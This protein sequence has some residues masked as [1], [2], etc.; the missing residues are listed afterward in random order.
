MEKYTLIARRIGLS[1]TVSP[2]VT[3]SN[4]ILLPI[5]TK[6]LAIADYGTWALIM[7]TINLLPALVA[8]GLPNSLVR[9]G[10]AAKDKHDIREIFYSMGFIVL[11]VSLI[12]SGL[13]FLFAPQIAASLFQNNLTIALLLI[14]NILVACLIYFVMQ[15]FVTFQQIKIYSVLS[16]F[17]AYLST[18]LIA[19]FVLS[20]HG[21]EGAV[22]ALLIQ[23][24]VGFALMMYLIVAQI[25]FAIPKFMD[26]RQYFAYGRAIIAWKPIELGR[27]FKR[28]LSCLIFLGCRSS[29][30]LFAGIHCREHDCHDRGTITIASS[31]SIETL[32]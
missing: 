22:V 18:A 27:K 6:N 13:F 7:V 8:L 23:Q 11:A 15:Y 4:I 20:G 14:P 26:V 31:S 32:R 1:A 12:V 17:N 16:I 29:R 2:L 24:L 30:L 19:Y 25:G 10:A 3:L 21:L 9:F 5:L 28:S